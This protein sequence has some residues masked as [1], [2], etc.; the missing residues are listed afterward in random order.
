[1]LNAEK[2]LKLAE[3]ENYIEII[4]ICKKRNHFQ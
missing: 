3:Q 2:I 4:E 1:M